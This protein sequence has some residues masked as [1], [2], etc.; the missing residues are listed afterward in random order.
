MSTLPHTRTFTH[1]LACP[2][3]N[4]LAFVCVYV[5]SVINV[6][7]MW[8]GKKHSYDLEDEAMIERIKQFT[9]SIAAAGMEKHAELL[10]TALKRLGQADNFVPNVLPPAPLLIPVTHPGR[11]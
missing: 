1:T 11:T 4:T 7:K 10:E 9:I 2:Y 6:I 8:M 3:S 5:F